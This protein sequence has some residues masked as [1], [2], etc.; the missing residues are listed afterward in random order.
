MFITK[1]LFHLSL[2]FITNLLFPPPSVAVGDFDPQTQ[3]WAV[4]TLDKEKQ[5]YRVPR[6]YV[7]FKAENPKIF[8]ERL[9]DA[10]ASRNSV[11]RELKFQLYVDC[12]NLAGVMDP[13]KRLMEKIERLSSRRNASMAERES[14]QQMLTEL[15]V[16][17]RYNYINDTFIMY[18]LPF[19]VRLS[20]KACRD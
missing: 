11:Q 13:D 1:Y 9:R 15:R 14:Q 4:I 5:I 8:A 12:M 17:L 7:L 19:L 10:V 18:L 6:V 16:S 3:R 2:F 20:K